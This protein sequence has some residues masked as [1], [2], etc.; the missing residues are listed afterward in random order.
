MY[1][2]VIT[3]AAKKSL[4]RLNKPA[5]QELLKATNIL[6]ETPY[7]GEKLQGSLSFLYSFHFKFK[8]VHY[9]AAYSINE[10]KK[11][12]ILHLVGARENFYD[13]LRR[14]FR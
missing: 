9:R 7:L 2:R 12:I 11:L 8:N 6:T 5:Q 10:D 13:R 1:Q 3:P 4:K 14:L